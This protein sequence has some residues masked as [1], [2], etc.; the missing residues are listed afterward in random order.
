M[1]FVLTPIPGT[2]LLYRKTIDAVDPKLALGLRPRFDVAAQLFTPERALLQVEAASHPLASNVR[3]QSTS[4]YVPG[5][6]C[7]WIASQ[8]EARTSPANVAEAQAR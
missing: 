1:T 5:S 6:R 7:M 8:G 3:L 2:I 4:V